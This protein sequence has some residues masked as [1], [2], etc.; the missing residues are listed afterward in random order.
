MSYWWILRLKAYIFFW[1]LK[2]YWH[3]CLLSPNATERMS[4]FRSLPKFILAHLF[5]HNHEGNY[6]KDFIQESKI[7]NFD[8]FLVKIDHFTDHFV[9]KVCPIINQEWTIYHCIKSFW[10]VGSYHTC[11]K[12]KIVN[13]EIWVWESTTQKSYINSI[14][15]FRN[16]LSI[17][18]KRL[19][20]SWS[21]WPLKIFSKLIAILQFKI[22]EKSL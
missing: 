7:A 13:I 17:I 18:I 15:L 10:I 3:I 6:P 20:C 12:L 22:Q 1:R 11:Y 5:I 4:H 2:E 14:Y 21:L 16:N 19:Y 9:R 8:F